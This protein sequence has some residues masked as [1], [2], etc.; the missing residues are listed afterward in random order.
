[1]VKHYVS[2]ATRHIQILEI[3]GNKD[4]QGAKEFGRQTLEVI[5]YK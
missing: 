4:L 2:F 3:S 1:M 5:I